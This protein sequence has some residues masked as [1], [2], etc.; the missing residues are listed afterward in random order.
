MAN[1]PNRS[2]RKHGETFLGDGVYASHDGHQIKLRVS[3]NASPEPDHV[4]YLAPATMDALV[5]FSE[6][7]SERGR[8][9]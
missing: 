7:V 8:F 1:H 3:R 6:D 5:E 4:I 2:Q 9:W